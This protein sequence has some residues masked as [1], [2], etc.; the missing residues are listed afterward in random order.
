[1]WWPSEKRFFDGFVTD[2]YPSSLDG[3]V[4]FE[5]WSPV[6]VAPACIVSFGMHR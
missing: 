2:Y 1:M 4:C 6:C 3:Q 5:A